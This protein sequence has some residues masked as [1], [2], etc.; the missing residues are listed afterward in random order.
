MNTT[1][2]QDLEKNVLQAAR[3]LAAEFLHEA[4]TARQLAFVSVNLRQAQEALADSK[5]ALAEA[6]MN[7]AAAQV[8]YLTAEQ[9]KRKD[10]LGDSS[11]VALQLVAARKHLWSIA[12]GGD[13]QDILQAAREYGEKVN[14]H[15]L[16]CQQNDRLTAACTEAMMAWSLACEERRN[17]LEKHEQAIAREAKA[18]ADI[19][20]IYAQKN[21]ISHSYE[22]QREL[23]AAVLAMTGMQGKGSAFLSLKLADL[24]FTLP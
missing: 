17:L 10:Y 24:D 21:A 6:D 7:L 4:N 9:K 12:M 16:Q 2:K 1:N 14:A 20:A 3:T 22:I 23:V 8:R 5:L 19:T 11:P 13:D 18:Q 15:W